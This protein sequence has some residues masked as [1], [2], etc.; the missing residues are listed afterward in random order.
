[1][2][3][4]K[5]RILIVDD[6]KNIRRTLSMI[7]SE[8]GYYIEEADTAK[9][10]LDKLRKDDFDLI[11]L[12]LKL[13]DDDGVRLIDDIKSISPSTYI[14]MISGHGSIQNAVE[15]IKKGAYDFFEKPLDRERILISVGHC[16][17]KKR[18]VEELAVLRE[19][20]RDEEIIGKSDKI[21]EVLEIIK[22]VSS[23]NARVFITGESGTGKE[24]VAKYIH[25]NSKR[26]QFPFIKVNCAAIP[27]ELI[28]S[29]LF[30]Y[31]KGA[32]SGANESKKGLIELADKGTLFLDE[33]ADMSLAAQAK[34]LRVIQTGEFS[35]LGS[36]K[37]RSVDIRVIAATN[38][39]IKK[40]ISEER[41]REDLFY[42]LNV[43]SINM[44]PLRE[45]SEDIPLFVDR[46]IESVCRENGLV[47]KRITDRALK[48]LMEYSWPGNV[49]ELKNVIESL[50]ILS[51][52]IIDEPDIPEYILEGDDEPLPSGTLKKTKEDIERRM[53]LDALEKSDWI[54]ARAA[55]ILGIE[56][57]TLHKRINALGIKREKRINN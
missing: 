41:F 32:F 48:R 19:M 1:M 8:E 50:V 45:R 14:I 39:D 42:R 31:E 34:I 35:R 40:L 53:I 23:T 29:E 10:A 13:P 51:E 20:N 16:I 7:L 21:L 5:Y 12:D 56:R 33:I 47:K 15:A 6:E 37:F 2:T 44:P 24:L 22:K 26:R 17:E 11:L 28:E 3:Q 18:L 25:Q 36:E 55:R 57:T 52:D 4:E 38:K 54:I 43:V 9:E 46:F 27:S 30:G 49:R